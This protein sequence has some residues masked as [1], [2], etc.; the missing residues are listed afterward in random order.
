MSAP[1]A[2]DAAVTRR[3]RCD[4]CECVLELTADELLRYSRGDW[5]RC[6][7]LAMV[8]EIDEQAVRPNAGTELERRHRQGRR[9]VPR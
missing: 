3:L 8:L 7:T 4:R 1:D 6:C 9:A 2:V 5:P